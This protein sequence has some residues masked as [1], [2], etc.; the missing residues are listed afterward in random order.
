MLPKSDNG[1]GVPIGRGWDEIV[2]KVLKGCRENLGDAWHSQKHGLEC[3]AFGLDLVSQRFYATIISIT[4]PSHS[5]DETVSHQRKS[6]GRG[7]DLALRKHGGFLF[8][9]KYPALLDRY[10]LLAQGQG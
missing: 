3:L 9:Y 2:G 6:G 10:L 8:H 4:P 5:P 7:D 1:F